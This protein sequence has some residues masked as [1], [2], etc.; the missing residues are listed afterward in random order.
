MDDHD[1]IARRRGR[2]GGAPAPSQL[3]GPPRPATI[4]RAARRASPGSVRIGPS[5]PRPRPAAP[6]LQTRPVHATVESV[7][8]DAARCW[9]RNS[10]MPT[11][12]QTGIRAL[13]TDDDFDEA[14]L[15]AIGFV[16][17][18]SVPVDGAK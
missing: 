18:G 15:E 9:I 16:F 11:S 13:E 2:H 7:I 17:H 10:S 12:N 5:A 6:A 1:P 8:F 4:A 3:T 14:R